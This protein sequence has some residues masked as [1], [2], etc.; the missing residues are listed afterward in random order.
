MGRHLWMRS[1]ASGLGLRCFLWESEVLTKGVDLE[2][3]RLDW[4]ISSLAH[5][6]R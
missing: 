5:L 2:N 1:K 4:G 3:I 6:D